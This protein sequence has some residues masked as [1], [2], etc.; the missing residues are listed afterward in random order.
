LLGVVTLGA[1][2]AYDTLKHGRLMLQTFDHY[3]LIIGVVVAFVAAAISV[4]WMV[5]YL[6]RHG[7]EI[8]G[9]YRVI[10]AVLATAFLLTA[11]MIWI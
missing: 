5:S 3:A 1:A 9:Y 10:I 6:S 4:K 2:T 8:F 11:K 7:L